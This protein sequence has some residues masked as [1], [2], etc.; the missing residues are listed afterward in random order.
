MSRQNNTLLVIIADSLSALIAKGEITDRYYNP[1]NYFSNVH[2]L[3]I[4]DDDIASLKKT[5]IQRLVG[6]AKYTIHQLPPPSF[7]LTLGYS[8]FLLS[9]WAKK[10]LP[11]IKTT[12]PDLIRCYGA[13]LNS[14]VALKAKSKYK[15]P[16]AVSL[17]GNYQEEYSRRANQSFF[18][19]IYFSRLI[20]LENL[21]LKHADIILPVYKPII[22]RIKN[23]HLIKYSL[24][25]NVIN[26]SSIIK[27]T[28]YKL[29]NPRKI[30]S[31]S[32]FTKG[33]KNPTN[34][35]KALVKIPNCEL[36]LVGNGPLLPA[37]TDLVSSLNLNHRVFFHQHIQNNQLCKILPT[38]DLFVVQTDNFEISKAVLEALLTGMPIIINRRPGLQVPELKGKHVYFVKNTT[39]SYTA[40]ITKL[41]N[42]LKLRQNLGS[43]AKKISQKK[44]SPK[45]TEKH[46][47]NIYQK[48]LHE[49]AH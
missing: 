5:I 24:S 37:L 23:L 7:L 31:I 46:F 48:L 40:G 41:L 28:S 14:F 25:Y 49:N 47:V 12:S 33:E 3:L 27:K 39:K 32:R 8:P 16:Y 11:E 29:S 18:D 6:T 20:K 30:I 43:A 22:S 42:N 10:I 35:I 15:I 36:H 34:I 17:H 19:R 21:G 9:F 4:N 13:W 1:G 45:I 44:W 26:P 38:F 2:L